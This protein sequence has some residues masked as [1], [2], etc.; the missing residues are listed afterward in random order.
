MANEIQTQQPQQP[1]AIVALAAHKDGLSHISDATVSKGERIRL[2][3]LQAM[4]TTPRIRECSPAEIVAAAYRVAA[5]DLDASGA[6]GEVWLIPKGDKLE[7][8][9]G[10]QGLI[11]LAYRSGQVSVVTMGT[12]RDGDVWEY[13]AADVRRPIRHVQRSGTAPIIAVW[14]QCVLTSGHVIAGVVLSDEFDGLVNAAKD[15]LGKGFGYSPWAKYPDRMVALV[16][17][18][19]CLKRAPKSVVQMPQQVTIDDDGVLVARN[20][21]RLASE[22]VR[23]TQAVMAA[24]FDAVP[25]PEPEV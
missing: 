10:V 15:R 5:L 22:V 17:L 25:E 3:F 4:R 24:E 7:V 12:V 6:T 14:A 8:W 20:Q 11:K 13:D 19:R 21:G 18:R 2:A 9:P 23:E 16:A 1:Q